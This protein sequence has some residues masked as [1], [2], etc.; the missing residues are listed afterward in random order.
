MLVLVTVT[1]PPLVL[2]GPALVWGAVGGVLT[3]WTMLLVIPRKLLSPAYS[4][5]TVLEPCG[6]ELV[7]NAATPPP[8]RATGLPSG[9]PLV[10]N[11]TFPAGA[12]PLETALVTVSVKVTFEPGKEGFGEEVKLPAVVAIVIVA[13]AG[14]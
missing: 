4:A 13:A 3:T 7:M 9:T 10:L 14:L 11:C 5:L 8:S 12:G 2:V 6:R 1:V